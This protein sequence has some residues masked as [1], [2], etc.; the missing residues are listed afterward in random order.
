MKCCKPESVGNEASGSDNVQSS[1]VSAN[2]NERFTR[3]SF[4]LFLHSYVDSSIV[5]NS[6]VNANQNGYFTR[7]LKLGTRM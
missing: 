7:E 1:H 4:V 6:H 5:Q 3:K 2:K